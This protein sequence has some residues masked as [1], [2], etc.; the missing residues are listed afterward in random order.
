MTFYDRKK[1]EVLPVWAWPGGGIVRGDGGDWSH[2][3]GPLG[4]RHGKGA[5]HGWGTWPSPLIRWRLVEHKEKKGKGKV[6]EATW[7][8]LFLH[9]H[10]S[11]SLTVFKDI[12]SH[13]GWVVKE[14]RLPQWKEAAQNSNTESELRA[15]TIGLDTHGAPSEIRAKWRQE[16]NLQIFINIMKNLKPVWDRKILFFS[17]LWKLKK[18]HYK[19]KGEK[20]IILQNQT[21]QKG[22]EQKKLL[23]ESLWV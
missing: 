21:N 3:Q 5:H 1:W 15:K 12:W 7:E 11:H 6:W 23:G 14:K 9:W 16:G 22:L 17:L 19:Q 18:L 8:V 20:K 13:L 2:W 4:G 10:R